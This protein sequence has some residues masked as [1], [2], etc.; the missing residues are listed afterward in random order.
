MLALHLAL[1][2]NSSHFTSCSDLKAPIY[3]LLAMDWI[4]GDVLQLDLDGASEQNSHQDS[5]HTQILLLSASDRH[6]DILKPA[7][8][9][10]ESLT[11]CQTSSS[12]QGSL[13]PFSLHNLFSPHIFFQERSAATVRT[14]TH[15]LY[16]IHTP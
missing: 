2:F 12:T 1:A 10:N 15:I 3:R 8:D 6:C 5:F 9:N 13:P 14:Y 11:I 7:S 4:G 16:Y